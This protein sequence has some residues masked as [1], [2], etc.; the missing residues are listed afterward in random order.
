MPEL[1][2]DASYGLGSYSPDA[3]GP[4]WQSG[5]PTGTQIVRDEQGMNLGDALDEHCTMSASETD[6]VPADQTREPGRQ[7]MQVPGRARPQKVASSSLRKVPLN[8]VNSTSR[9]SGRYS[10]QKPRRCFPGASNWNAA[11]RT[12]RSTHRKPAEPPG[13]ALVPALGLRRQGVLPPVM[14]LS[15]DQTMNG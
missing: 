7:L 1:T 3:F 6:T 13:A 15:A 14:Q 10:S 8:C 2:G 5:A 11:A 4:L 9:C 12:G